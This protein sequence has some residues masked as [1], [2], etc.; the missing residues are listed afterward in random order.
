MRQRWTTSIVCGLAVLVLITGFSAPAEAAD[1]PFSDD[2]ESGLAN[3]TADAPWG[4][5]TAFYASPVYSATDSPSTFYGASVDASL[6]LGSSIDL[7]A[8]TAPVLR[9]KHRHQLEDGHDF[10]YVETSTDGGASW[11]APVA[12]YTGGLG[13][14]SREQVD[15]SVLA[16]YN[17]VRVRF[18]IVADGTVQQ[19]GWYIDDV[20]IAEAPAAVTL[21]IPSGMTPNSVDLA[22]SASA[23]PGFAAYRIYRSTV[24]GFDW[25][26]AT[27]VTEI[28]AIATTSHTDITVTP[29]TT[30]Y[31]RAMVL[32]TADLHRLGNE[33]SAATPAGMDYPFLD[34]G[35]GGNTAWTADP[36][37]ALS[38]EAAF[39]GS[40]SWSDSPGADYGNSIA[41]QALT[42]VGPID[43]TTAADPVLSFVHTWVFLPA[44]SGN[45][46]ISTDGGSSWTPLAVYTAGSSGGW[47]RERFEFDAYA[48]SNNVFVRF[49]ITTDPS[50]TAD[51]WH[52]DDISVAESPTEVDPPI[53]DQITSHSIRLTWSRCNDTLFSHYAVHRSSTPGAGIQTTLVTEISDQDTLTFTDTGLAIDTDYFYRVYA[54]SP[55]GTY[56]PDSA[57]EST[58][59]TGGN[60]YPFTEDFEG[61]LDSWNLTGDWDA[62]DTDQHSGSYSLTD[63]PSTTYPNSSNTQAWTSIDLTGST[64]PVLR[65][66]DRYA[67]ADASD[68]AILEVSTNGSTWYRIYTVT[69]TRTAWAEQSIDLSPW[70]ASDNLRIRFTVLTSNTGADDGWYIDDLSVAEHS[71][72]VALPFLDDLESGTGNW[73]TSS[74]A[75]SANT[76]HGGAWSA[77]STPQGSL[78]ASTEHVMVLGGELDLSTAVDPQLTYWI[79]GGTA[80]RGYFYPQVSINGGATW[81]NLPGSIGHSI[82]IPDWTRYQVSLAAYLQS[83]VRIRFRVAH[84]SSGGATNI[85]VDDVS[86]EEMP[87]TVNLAAPVPHLKAV[88]LSWTESALGDFD[89]YEVYRSTSANVTVANDL[90][91]S[92]TTSTETSFTDT[93]LSIGTT[94]YYRVFVYNSRHVATPSNERSATTVPLAFPFSDPMENLDSWDATGTWGPDGMTP[95]GG[96]FSLNDSPDD[97]SALSSNTFILTAINL[98]GS[99]WPVLRFWDRYGLSDDWGFLEVSINGSTW[100]RVYTPTG[101]R[102][103]WSEQS[104]DLSPWKTADNLRIRYTVI[105]G[106]ANADE[107]WYI[108]DLSVAEH[109]GSVALP[110]LDDLEAGTGSWLTSS[111]APSSDTPHGGL[112]SAQSTPQGML[113]DY[114]EHVMVLGGELDLSTA[115]DPQLTYWIRGGTAYRGY[116]NPQISINGGVTWANLPGGIGSS[117]NIPDWTR[118]QVSLAAYLQGGVRIC[119]RV[120]QSSS[121]GATNIFVDDVSIEEMPQS[122]TLAAPVPHLKSVDLSWTESTLPDFDRYEVY[123]STSANV[124]TANDLIF[125]STTSTDTSF[126]DTGLSIGTT[127]YYR[128]FVINS[129]HVATPSNE[130]SATT[131]PLAFPF[132]DP[133]ENLDN[134]DA[135]GGWGPDGIT[136]HGGSF[137]LNDSPGDNSPL[138]SN[139]YILTAINLAGTNWP[140]LRF[141]DRY[142]LSDDWGYLEVST[143]GTTWLRVY[144]PT[145][146]RT[147]WSEQSIDLSP[148]K[149]ADNLRIRYTVITGGANADEGWYI[150]DLS[151]T[152]NVGNVALPFFDDLES[153]AGNWLTSSWAPSSDTPRGGLWSAQS[154]PQGSMQSYTEHVMELAGELDLSA[155]VDPQLTFWVRGVLGDNAGFQAQVSTTGG[156]TW[157]NLPGTTLG[158]YWTGGWTRFQVSLAG[159]LQSDVRIRFRVSQGNYAQGNDI[160]VDDVAIEEMPPTVALATPDQITISTMRLQWND[161]NDP[162]FAS[163]ALYRS[164]TSTVDTTSELVTT[165]TEQTTTEFIDTGLQARRTYYYRLYFVDTA[166]VYSPSNST[167]AMTLGALL[168]FTDDFETDSGVWT[169]TGD[170]GRVVAGGT[171]GSTSLADSPGDLTPNLDAWAVTGIDL[172][173]TTWPVLSFYERYDFAG[174]WGRVEISINGGANWTILEGAT[175]DQTGWIHRRFDLSPWKDQTQV[176]VRFFLDANSGVPADGWHIDDLTIGE[177]P[178]LGSGGFPFFDGLESGDGAW[179]N[180]PWSLTGDDPY[181]GS[182]SILDTLNSRMANSELL[183]T[184]G[185]RIDLSGSTDPLLTIQVRGNLPNNNYFRTEVSTD[186]GVTWQNLPDLYL[187]DNWVSADWLRLQTPLSGYLVP[188]LRLRFR[189]YGNYGGDSNLLLDNISI[190]EQTPGAPTLNAPAWGASEPTVRPALVVNNAVEFQSDPMTYEYQVFDDSGLTSVV[191]QIP[192]VAG[193]IDTTSWTVDVDL[194]PDT[195]YWWRCRAT[196]DSAHTGGWMDTATFFVQLTDHPPTVPVLL[197]PADGGE[198]PDLTGRL[199]WLESTDPDAANG[200]YV[201]SYRVQVDDD[202]AFASPNIDQPGIDPDTEAT[203]AISVML[204]ELT[205]SGSLVTG[206]LYHWRVNAKDSHGVASDWSAG[207]RR[208]VFGTDTTAPPC[209]IV[210]PVHDQTVTDTPIAITGTADDDLSGIDIVEVSTDGGASWMQAVGNEAWTHQWWPALSGDYQL[211]CRAT[212]VAGNPG[213]PSALITVHAELDRT[214]S[215]DEGTASVPEDGSELSVVVHMS[216][217]R[218]VEVNADLV[219]S[220]TA[221]SGSDYGALPAQVRFFPGQTTL[222]FPIEILDDSLY[223]GNETIVIELANPNLPDITFGVNGVLT[224]T[225]VDDDPDPATVIFADGF[226]SGDVSGWTDSSP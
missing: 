156:L 97:V 164:E 184:Y 56:S 112:W 207:P 62:T 195:Q 5:T 192:S 49:R 165:I 7:A 10:G 211:S 68:W 108:D 105:T 140:V 199:T 42:L 187:P 200:D 63:S 57:A 188:D 16:G 53:L 147:A 175:A 99:T 113:R 126:T 98:A 92:S 121:S 60:P 203:G 82:N 134:W 210:S 219:V 15:L 146:G 83:G 25:Q 133:M 47:L 176:W 106:G 3:W 185:D 59:R 102:T 107:G 89:R 160:F 186:Q 198:L 54:V 86:V 154:T 29:K 132:S 46:E 36:P 114:A 31:Y 117:I 166:D 6:S 197:S 2:F 221:Q 24:P 70:K 226:E 174:H 78:L 150:D 67:F 87:Q 224:V 162:S 194:L 43:L 148:W 23:E 122:V 181:A 55:Y 223:E 11:S 28:T 128:V 96:S 27:L 32:T 152:E 88:D 213:A 51:G 104:I 20:L 64:W 116:F 66:W 177:N 167:S 22:W 205:G 52:V 142:G 94:Y 93:G 222:S 225:L 212:D 9:F 85:F 191:A 130:R 33:V 77:Q 204:S 183:L 1:Y 13:T 101:G 58:A 71:G 135:T 84:S 90:I 41:S 151:V 168:P 137:S 220:G 103:A 193:G 170:W 208:F 189:V 69:N 50:A 12:T 180:G 163:Y 202:P 216:A 124:T 214:M 44:D 155:A 179:L 100:V 157:V 138:S 17:D 149:T 18:R 143:N 118:Y 79:R 206:T 209:T 14:W 182:A 91:F 127:Y 161:L 129:R 39:S 76:P 75:T 19:D 37:W 110:F 159:Y 73:L 169:L 45:V 173:G 109:V 125:S 65:F 74:W 178:L 72:T 48:W 40:H 21:S 123:R 120:A 131:V 217:P 158:Q 115:V 38:T 215:F 26:S 201:A 145:S 196:D 141:W 153:G 139:T 218:A 4:E 95:H 144:T 61:S 35:E 111:W 81:A 190:G 119:F 80:Y 34:N 30:Y 172:S 136:P 171:G 8:A